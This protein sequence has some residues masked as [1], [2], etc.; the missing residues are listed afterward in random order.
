MSEVRKWRVQVSRLAL[1]AG[2]LLLL[3][4]PGLAQTESARILGTVTDASGAALPG[5]TVTV[6]EIGTE[7]AVTAN[8]DDDG[9]YSVT[10]LAPGRY[11]IEVT[12]GGFKMTR[13]EVTLEVQQ[14]ANLDF[15][16]EPG[17]VS[18][19]I[20]VTADAP[21]VESST[22]AIGEAI[23]GR[24]I[25]ELPLNGRNVLEL[26]R[27]VPGVTQGVPSGFATGVGGNAETF[28][29]RNTGGAALS[30]N[31]QRTQA[32]NFL[33]DGVDNNESLVNTI[34]IFP[35]A[36]AVQE[37]RVQTSVAPAEF[38]R[39]G[40]GIVNAA[41]RS[42]RQDFFGS[43]FTFIRN[44]N[45]DARPTFDP[46]KNEFRRG[47]FGGTLGGPLYL[48]W[49]GEGGP[50][51]LGGESLFFFTDYEGLRQFLPLGN[52]IATVPTEAFRRGDF[53]ALLNPA[54]SGLSDAIQ[55]TDP[56][57]GLPVPGNRLDL[58][59][60][61]RLNPVGL[62]YLNAFPAP[63]RGSQV[64][65]NY[66]NTRNEILDQDTFDLRVDGNISQ[67]HQAFGRISWG[68]ATQ[69]T[70]SRL[71]TLPAGFG[72]GTNFRRT[73]QAVVGLTSV[74]TPSLVNELRVQAARIN[75]GFQP[76][77]FE[78]AIS[79]E[80]G[81][82]NANLDPLRGGGALIGGF[83]GQLEY[84]GDFGLYTVPQNTYQL[85][86]SMT[87]TTGNHTLRFG[88]QA[89]RRH[90]SLFRPNRGKGFFFLV[91]NGEADGI[92]LTGFEQSDLLVGFVNNYSVGPPFGTVGT[93]NWENAAFAQDDWRVTPRLTLNLGLRYEY[94][95]NPTEQ[96]G[97]QANF[98]LATG[99]L[100]VASGSGDALVDQDRNDFSPR[101]GFAYDLG[102]DGRRVIRGGYGLFYFLD[103]G[104]IDNQLAQNPPFSGFSQFNYS[105]GF[106]IALSGRCPDNTNDSRLCTGP[107]PSGDVSN[108]DVNNP[109][110]VSVLAI[111]PDNKTANVHQFNVQY[112]HQLTG[113]T[114]LSVG[115]VGTRG[116]N[117]STYFNVNGG[118]IGGGARPFPQ[119]GDVRVR[120]DSGE[121]S[122][123]SL[124]LQL[125]RR[126]TDG[127][128]YLVSYTFSKTEDNAFGAFDAPDAGGR[129]IIEDFGRSNLDF[130]HVFTF[131]S[132]AD[133][134][135][136]RGRR[137]GSDISRPVDYILG[138]W[139][140]NTIVRLQSGQTFDVRR[141]G[142][143]LDI[144]G[145]PYGGPDGRYLNPASFSEVPSPGGVP[146]RQGN[147][148]RNG[149]R[150]RPFRSAN[151]GLAKNFNFTESARLQFRTEFFNL[152]N[153]PQFGLPERDIA[154][155][156]D[157]GRIR[158]T[159]LFTNRQIQFGLR[160]EF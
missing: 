142:V 151:L 86:D 7:R 4:T 132:V 135:F 152:T 124:Q 71:T 61:N 48:P 68:R 70:T 119:L 84:T 87:Y 157:F 28:V 6:T 56:L 136:G 98:D 81:I 103:R 145:D 115:Y 120:D 17:G 42:G 149:L 51:L 154:N 49:F 91:G 39:G 72:S 113:E 80:L 37:F 65:G 18:E 64:L 73:R 15:A 88:G 50:K 89:L 93:F 83:N 112:Q 35:S 21:L 134:P 30:V 95:T 90:V 55:L 22:S 97:R 110:N 38:G 27:L 150:G 77:F 156:N 76:P 67:S 117:L 140:L 43:L 147:Q 58:L 111:L 158:T 129:F 146:S 125:E 78:R 92:R 107:L 45:F 159:Q 10:N 102:G 63:N 62:A 59:P 16:L 23:T 100:L 144:T 75:Y 133:I 34:Q 155:A 9:A 105:N 2:F 29:N 33:L 99:R 109:Q 36:D 14:V 40:G 121:S 128:Q 31:G 160:L 108:V 60:G 85:V 52:D 11:R 122:Y 143:L 116:R 54:V 153:T 26:A 44:D 24:Q 94:F 13:Q 32:N 19:V 47:Q 66:Q 138:G 46:Q 101:V 20:E 57:T 114:A 139:Q 127:F 96:Y 126:F 41:T 148:E 8:A 118:R 106:R 131:S 3:A 141:G 123:D 82:P 12:Q 5:A 69:E 104:G 1:C 25:V 130:P 79:A 53:S 137:F 74:L